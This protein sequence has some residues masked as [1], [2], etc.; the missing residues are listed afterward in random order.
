M[1]S[2]RSNPKSVRAAP[3]LP[4]ATFASVAV[5]VSDRQR[6]L[7][8]Y[9]KCLGL[10]AIDRLDHWVTVGRKGQNGV[11]HLCQTSEY[12]P[13]LPLERG[14]T[15]IHLRLPGDFETACAALAARGVTFTAPPKKEEWG[16]GAMI[17]DP[18]GNEIALSPA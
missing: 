10:D 6:A 9:T 16:W 5:V 4:K 12:D 1:S 7:E 11:L 3:P 18:D 15:G 2:A 8:W 17:A 14:N 13:S